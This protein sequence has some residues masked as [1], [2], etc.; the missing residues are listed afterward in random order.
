MKGIDGLQQSECRKSGLHPKNGTPGGVGDDN[1]TQK[2]SEGGSEHCS[3]GEPAEGCAAFNLV[4]CQRGYYPF[5]PE[6]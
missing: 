5:L 2:R 1:A 3:E 6:P 4:R